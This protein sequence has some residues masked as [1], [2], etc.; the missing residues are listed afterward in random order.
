VQRRDFLKATTAAGAAATA[1]GLAMA[2]GTATGV[3]KPTTQ[4]QS[5]TPEWMVVIRV[6]GSILYATKKWGAQAGEKPIPLSPEHIDDWISDCAKHG[7][8]TVL[9]R[10][11]C[12]GTLTYPSKFTALPGEPPLPN[13]NRGMG[14]ASVNQGWPV[15][16]WRWLGNQCKRFN[17]LAAA[18]KAAHRHGLELCL[19]FHVFDMVGSWCRRSQWPAGGDRAWDPDLW[20]WSRDQTQ[21]LAG[22]PCYADPR[23]RERRLAEIGEALAFG[24][25]GVVLGFFSHCD[26]QA[27]EKRCEFGYNPVVVREY[28]RRNGVDP[29]TGAVDAHRFYA[30]H[31]E[32]FTQFVRQASELVH[33]RGKKL[34]CCTRTDGVHGWGGKVAGGGLVGRMEPRDLRDGKSKLPLAGGFYLESEKWA[35]EGLLDGLLC[36][37]P[38]QDGIQAIRQ[39]KHET[40]VP[41]YLWRKYTGFKGRVT[42]MGLDGFRKEVLA[43]RRGEIDGY[44]LLIMQI[45]QHPWFKPDWRDVLAPPKG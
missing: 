27:G 24:V 44:C 45:T 11:N 22:V 16:D 33:D 43:T 36:S 7:V 40:T 10:A 9:W 3:A 32:Y 31:G 2:A 18:V 26:G 12:A 28:K 25:D 35:R 38:L 20:L 8:T 21:R 13:P 30:L 34:I 23:V 42:P 29:L 37:A 15:E 41:V 39:L 6:Y 5:A 4:T 19:D 1:R 14:V 17:T